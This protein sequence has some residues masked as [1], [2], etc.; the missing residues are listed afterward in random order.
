MTDEPKKPPSSALAVVPRRGVLVRVMT[1]FTV[2]PVELETTFDD[3]SL[4]M[5]E[6]GN[7]FRVAQ[8]L[9]DE[10]AAVGTT[11]S[12][13]VGSTSNPHVVT[14][15]QVGLA[16]VTDDA[17]LKADVTGYAEKLVL[18]D[19]DRLWVADSAASFAAKRADLATINAYATKGYTRKS[20]HECEPLVPDSWNDEFDGGSSDPAARGW[21]VLQFGPTLLAATRIGDIDPTIV[22]ATAMSAGQ[23]RSTVRNGKLYIQVGGNS[24]NFLYIYKATTSGAFCYCAGLSS[25][26]HSNV[27]NYRSLVITD[28]VAVPLGNAA[29]KSVVADQIGS[30]ISLNKWTS[31]T[32]AYYVAAFA[33]AEPLRPMAFRLDWTGSVVHAGI[34]AADAE[35]GYTTVI[36]QVPPTAWAPA[37]AGVAVRNAN[38]GPVNWAVIDYIRRYPS[39]SYF[40]V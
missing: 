11:V 20:I 16:N 26:N 4:E 14:K 24:G 9:Q 39:G 30:N 18:V 40:P 5:N 37:Y 32:Q 36:N 22:P 12:S 31:G 8:A 34:T 28:S 7:K 2:E 10:L 35:V 33:A 25:S 21:T 6:T 23:Y 29:S 27:Q 38:A 15:A 17:Q 3:A 13:H 1:P 19:A